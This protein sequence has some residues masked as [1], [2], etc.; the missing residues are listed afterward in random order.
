MWHA[1]TYELAVDGNWIADVEGRAELLWSED[2]DAFGIGEI[3][4]RHLKFVSDPGFPHAVEEWFATPSQHDP[5]AAIIIP[6]IRRQL[7][8]LDA[9]TIEERAD[10]ARAEAQTRAAEWRGS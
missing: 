8:I 9:A 3:E 10:E 7:P 4:L 6:D 5:I 2:F 1:F